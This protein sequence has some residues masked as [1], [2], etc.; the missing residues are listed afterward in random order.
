MGVVYRARDT[1][2]QRTVA[3]KV[4]REQPELSTP[5]LLLKEARAVSAL[6][7]PNI[8][9]VHEVREEAGQVFIVME[10]VDGRPVH[11]QIP[12]NGLPADSLLRYA[13][14]IADGLAHAHDRGVLHRD[15]KSANVMITREGRAKIV[16]FGL[17]SR[18]DQVPHDEVT[19]SNSPVPGD[20]SLAGTLAYIAPEV[21]QGAQPSV[22]TDLWSVGVLLY[23]MASGHLPFS[24]RT[25]FEMTAAILHAPPSPLPTHVPPSLRTIIARCLTREPAQR[26]QSAGELRAALEAVQSDVSTVPVEARVWKPRR[27]DWRFITAASLVA[28]LLTVLAWRIGRDRAPAAP[29]GSGR[30]VQVLSSD[31]EA[32]D[33]A[34][35]YDGTM[36]AYVAEDDA[37]R[38]DLFVSRVT[39][40]G[41]RV[42]L[43]D[44]DSRE[45]HPR[46]SP[47]GERI[48]FARRGTDGGS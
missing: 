17:A 20:S 32:S 23:E 44:D 41:G 2:L 30:L 47:D 25:M 42:R 38:T 19:R 35:S 27:R 4:L 13:I 3:L 46:F 12:I 33:P 15:I 36:I 40:G 18:F 5:D 28:V 37:G 24:G 43:T 14:Q 31:R 29:G 8:C 10:Y 26:Y 6:N 7:H 48:V 9:T 16:D 45:S 1:H 34:L 39:G 11:E 22:A 21:L